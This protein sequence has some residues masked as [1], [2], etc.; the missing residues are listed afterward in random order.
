VDAASQF[1]SIFLCGHSHR[2]MILKYEGRNGMV[3][4][5]M[6]ASMVSGNNYYRDPVTG[7]EAYWKDFLKRNA[8]VN[9]QKD[10]ENVRFIEREGRGRL[11]DYFESYG[12]G[13]ARVDVSDQGITVTFQSADLSQECIIRKLY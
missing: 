7:P 12:N 4:E 10:L 5:L 8:R 2:T 6:I 11:R 9:S 1:K 13:Y 3:S